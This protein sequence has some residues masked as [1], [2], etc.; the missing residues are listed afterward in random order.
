MRRDKGFN[1]IGG[2]VAETSIAVMHYTGIDAIR[3]QAD[4][5]WDLRYVAASILIAA[6]GGMAAFA[7]R[8]RVEGRLEPGRRLRGCSS[9]SIVGLHFT[10]MTAVTLTPDPGLVTPAEVMGRGGLALATSALAGFIL[11]ACADLVFME[12]L[13][14]RNTFVSL[15]SALNAVPAGL[16]FFDVSERLTVWNEAYAGLM[17]D[18]GLDLEPGSPR[19]SHIEAAAAAGWFAEN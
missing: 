18:C 2:T 19:R 12:R 15:R 16:A 6:A 14:Q 9:A 13:G 5:S 17:A 8:A 1:L 3:T 4:V 10:A 7:V 11:L